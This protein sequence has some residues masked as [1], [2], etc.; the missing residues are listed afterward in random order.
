M[1]VAVVRRECPRRCLFVVSPQRES[2]LRSSLNLTVVIV[3]SQMLDVDQLRE[4][5]PV[6]DLEAVGRP[7]K[8]FSHGSVSS[9]RVCRSR[10]SFAFTRRQRLI[11]AH[12]KV[13][14]LAWG[15]TIHCEVDQDVVQWLVGLAELA[16]L[17][18]AREERG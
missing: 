4:E 11:P 3:E 5:T 13:N 7:R 15:Q 18:H 1:A 12:D 2:R 9:R 10:S 6:K 17:L 14:V 16:D 8:S